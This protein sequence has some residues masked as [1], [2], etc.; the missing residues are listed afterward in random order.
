MEWIIIG[1][2]SLSA[3][4]FILSFFKQ[5]PYKELEK[6]IENMSIQMMQEI[7]YLK[8]KTKL[9]EEEFI[10]EAERIEPG[11]QTAGRAP[12]TVTRDV[13]LSMYE[14]GYSIEDIAVMTEKDTGHIEDLLAN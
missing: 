13:V 8:K 5:E 14:E 1:L 3:I 11:A 10:I 4:L 12:Y 6:Q 9:L 7:Y 2:F